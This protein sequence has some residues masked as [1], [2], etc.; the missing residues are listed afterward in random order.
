MPIGKNAFGKF[1]GKTG[2]AAALA[3]VMGSPAFA[4]PHPWQMGFQ[5]A[6][7][8]V[9]EQIEN[10]HTELFYI[11]TAVSLFV[12]ALLVWIALKFR[13]RVNP[14]PSK[15]HHNT[16][17]EVAW[18]I[19]PVIILVVIAVPSFKLL[20]Y[21][22]AIP[23]PDVHLRAIGKQW[24]WTYEYPGA[25]AGFTYDS[26]GLSDADA[27]KAGEPRLLGVDNV[28]VVPVNKVVEV[29]TTGADVIHSW[30][31]PQMGVKMDAVPG[32]LNHTWFKATQ[33]GT[34]YGECSELCGAK[35]A[36]MPIEVKV[37]SEADYAA[38]LASAKKKYAALDTNTQVAAK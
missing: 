32:R 5:P 33:L 17:L 18:T 37:V 27:K 4:L 16:L 2:L 19:I 12:L 21:E 34:F 9:M 22:A 3:A 29:E 15:V 38:W 6:A 7:S 26:L 28:V 10:F 30:A 25:N 13:A 24:F 20:Y 31:L 11:I 1:L 23:T 8:P 36:F 35:H 14:V